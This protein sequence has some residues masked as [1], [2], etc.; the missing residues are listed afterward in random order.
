VHRSASEVNAPN[1]LQRE[2]QYRLIY[3]GVAEGD[4]ASIF[5]G[6][7]DI[8]KVEMLTLDHFRKILAQYKV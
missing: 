6:Y 1:L 7:K 2:L 8:Y 4:L 5:D 3:K